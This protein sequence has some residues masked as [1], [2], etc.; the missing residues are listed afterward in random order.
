MNCGSYREKRLYHFKEQI[1]KDF[2]TTNGVQFIH[3]KRVNPNG[4]LFRPDFLIITKFG[5]LVIEID[6]RQHK[7]TGYDLTLEDSRMQQIYRD[8]QL[9]S[10]NNQV[11]FIRF[12]PD[13]YIGPQIEQKSRLEYLFA[14]I[15]HFENLQTI[16][17]NSGKMY[18]FYDG[19][20]GQNTKIEG[21]REITQ[22]GWNDEPNFDNI[23]ESE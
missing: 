10:P 23:E 13:E 1:V 11:L 20:T 22:H 8:V 3:D 9:N 12:N 14:L 16:G 15:K 17:V 4:S 2:L 18:L 5:Y 6:E 19:F 7:N 21:I